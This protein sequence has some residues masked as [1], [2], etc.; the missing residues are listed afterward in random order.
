MRV[1]EAVLLI[2]GGLV[3]VAA[4]AVGVGVIMTGFLI[5][6]AAAI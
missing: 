4:L 2:V 1:L 3:G 6:I 5:L